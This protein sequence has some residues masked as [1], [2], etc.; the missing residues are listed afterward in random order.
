MTERIIAHVDM[1]A[2]YASVEIRDDPS[3]A[4]RPVVVGGSSHG[5]G[6]VA[7]ASYEAR[8]YGIHS[9]MPM[10]R[11][12][13]LCPQLV[14]VSPNFL[15]YRDDSGKIMRVL[16]EFSP[17]L[18]PLS[19]DEA[20]V[21]LT[22]T[23]LALGRPWDLGGKIKE[24]IR[25]ETRLT[26]SVGIAPVK[27]VAKI[28]S[29]LEKPD[30]L[31]IVAPGTVE[32]FLRPLPIGRLWGVG[33]KTRETLEEFGIRTIGDLAAFD[34]KRLAARFGPHA[35]HLVELARGEDERG[36]VPESEAKSYSHEETFATDIT[37]RENLETVLL[38]QA[39]RVSRQGC[40]T[41]AP[42]SRLSHLD[43]SPDP[44]LADGGCGPHL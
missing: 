38:D 5:R 33:P 29:D 43:P 6:V 11:A 14:R 17:S 7:A 8:R 2:F 44:R 27:F 34:P 26:A 18:Q 1:D 13:R 39:I 21:D 41:E 3:L 16:G 42:V 9:A 30:G 22:G 24:R 19:L 25:E 23:G 10:A 31:V 12:E 20:F 36:V 37:D 15:K 40:T 35:E 4:G 28:A 32:Q